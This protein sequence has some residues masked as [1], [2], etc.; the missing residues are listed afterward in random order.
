MMRVG[1]YRP[2][3][4]KT[5][6]SQKRRM[7]LT[8]RRLLQTKAID[9]ESDLRGTLRNFGLK[10]GMVSTT[11]FEAR[12]RELVTDYPDLAGIA[13]ALLIARRVLREQL[14]ILH[15]QLLATVR[16]DE[17]CRRL[18]TMPGVGPVVALTFRATVDVPA[19]FTSSKAVGA[20]FGL[21]PRRY[22]SGEID[23]MGSISKSGDA[24][25][26]TILYEAAQSMLT[27]TIK[28]SWLKAWGMKIARHRGMRRAIV[29]VARRM[30][31]VMHRMW[32][33]GTE[34]RWTNSAA[35]AA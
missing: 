29:A 19:R 25:M 32:V 13:E 20:V 17:V 35:V 15:R 33:D 3:H 11:K 28:W 23:R 31:V 1:L 14:G 4:V 34:F 22:Q 5:L 24:M 2:V 30:A 6:A 21:T 27:R 8:S 10:V 12:I 26:R 18:M 7:L 9:I 16:H